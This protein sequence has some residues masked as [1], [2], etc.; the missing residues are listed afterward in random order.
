MA[1][2]IEAR[3]PEY[4]YSSEGGKELMDVSAR[5]TSKGQVTIPKPVRDALELE[6]GDSV[7]FRVEEGRAVLAKVP[8]FLE[9]AGSVPVPPDKRGLPWSEIRRQASEAIAREYR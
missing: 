2:E 8:D 5:L 9:L 7:L 3:S 1:A 4:P 6:N